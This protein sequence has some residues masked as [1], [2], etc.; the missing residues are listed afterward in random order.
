MI[1]RE[2]IIIEK[3]EDYQN[4]LQYLLPQYVDDDLIKQL[5]SHIGIQCKKTVVEF[6]YYENDY[7]SSYY[8]FYAKKLQ[9]FP[10]ECYRILFYEDVEEC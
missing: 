3:L 1:V 9:S 10:K 6:P 2:K 7:L 8:I 4:I 5:A